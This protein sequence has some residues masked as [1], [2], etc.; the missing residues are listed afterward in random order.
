MDT[1]NFLPANPLMLADTMNIIIKSLDMPSLARGSQ[2]CKLWESIMSA[3]TLWETIANKALLCP[4][5]DKCHLYPMTAGQT[6]KSFVGLNAVGSQKRLAE[7]IKK[8]A[9]TFAKNTS[10]NLHMIPID[11]ADESYKQCMMIGACNSRT[12]RDYMTFVFVYAPAFKDLSSYIKCNEANW[13]K[14]FA[15]NFTPDYNGHDYRMLSCLIDFC[16]KAENNGLTILNK[17]NNLSSDMYDALNYA[18]NKMDDTMD[19]QA[20]LI[21]SATQTK[22]LNDADCCIL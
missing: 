6:L 13:N 17:K 16:E 18:K 8:W 21:M 10:Y 5:R 9:D 12:S 14:S 2:V 7:F 4:L 11:P 1:T 22:N 20:K 15:R 3:D 19:E